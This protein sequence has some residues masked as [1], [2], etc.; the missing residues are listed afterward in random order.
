M[1]HKGDTRSTMLYNTADHIIKEE[2]K[3]KKINDSRQITGFFSL[4]EH[5]DYFDKLIETSDIID[6]CVICG[7]STID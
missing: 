3:H 1:L 7:D 4:A 2:M 6:D 5:N